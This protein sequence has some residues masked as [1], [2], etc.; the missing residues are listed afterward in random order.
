MT[1]AVYDLI[2][3]NFDFGLKDYPIWDESYRPILNTAILD[4]YK[5]KQIGYTNPLVFKDRLNMRMSLIMR[6][7]YNALYEAKAIKF[8]PLYNIE[9]HETFSHS[10]DNSG[11]VTNNGTTDF[12]TNNT[13]NTTSSNEINTTINDEGNQSTESTNVTSQ[14]PSEE[15]LEN[16]FESNIYVDGGAKLKNT[17]HSTDEN[18]QNTNSSGTVNNAIIGNDKTINVNNG[19]SKNITT[20]T[21]SK[22][23]VG[24]SAGLPFSRAMTQLKDYLDEYQL[25]QQV[26]DELKD[27]FMNVW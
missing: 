9:I 3:M 4:F 26:I 17:Q 6:N 8:N 19:T 13:N 14:Y 22:D 20:E 23:T 16:D 10:I 12:T 7:K 5:F 15:M 1:K 21:Y 2:L 24:S 27:L 18:N 11:Q 25:D